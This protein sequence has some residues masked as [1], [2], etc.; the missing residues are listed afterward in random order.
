MTDKNEEPK[1][2]EGE[3][4]HSSGGQDISGIKELVD[5]FAVPFVKGQEEE[6]K[7]AKIMASV[8]EKFLGYVAFAVV[9][10]II[11]AGIALFLGEKQLTKD[12]VLALIA[13]LGGFGFGRGTS[14]S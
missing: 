1:A 8:L 13:F 6:T 12:I 4:V 7:R 10:I 14:K 5:A 11:L 2:A 3:V 9:L